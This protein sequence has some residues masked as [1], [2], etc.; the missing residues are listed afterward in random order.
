MPTLVLFIK[1]VTVVVLY[2]AMDHSLTL[3]NLLSQ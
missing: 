2:V 1:A 3:Q